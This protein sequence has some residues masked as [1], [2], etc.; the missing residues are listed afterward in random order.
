MAINVGLVTAGLQLI[1]LILKKV[2]QTER[3]QGKTG[4]QKHSLVRDFAKAKLKAEDVEL[5]DIDEFIHDIVWLMNKHK[6]FTK[7]GDK[8][9]DSQ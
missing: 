6:I 3:N 4:E 7:K 2:W 5:D 9:Y 1:I 8:G